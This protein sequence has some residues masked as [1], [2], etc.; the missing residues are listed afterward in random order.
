VSF[1][2]FDAPY[3]VKADRTRVKQVLLNLLSNAIKYN[4]LGGT[5]VVDYIAVP[6]GRIRICIRDSGEG[7]APGQLAQLFQ[8]FN[9]LGQAANVEEG[10]GIGLVV[11]KRLIESMGG[12]IGVD[13]TVGAGSVFWIEMDLTAERQSLADV[14]DTITETRVDANAALRT[15]LY[16]EDNPA[17]LMLVED[18][19]A[20]RADLR[21]LTALDGITGV[22][23]ARMEKPDVIL[24]DINLPGISGIKAMKLLAADAGTTNIPVI[25]LSANAIPRDI[26]VGLE[27]GFFRYLTKPIKVNEF[28]E[29]LDAALQLAQ[30]RA[31]ATAE[32]NLT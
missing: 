1:P 5:V 16:V 7:L 10:T 31:P 25:A 19:I 28:M 20:R 26:K 24:M 22:A 11:C 18:L 3:F 30:T 23:I 6:P 29:T 21:M 9:R 13:S 32:G 12:I 8:P 15:L 4:R 2:H 27:A 17:N 14:M